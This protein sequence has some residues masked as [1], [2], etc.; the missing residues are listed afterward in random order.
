MA[1]FSCPKCGSSRSVLYRKSPTM[2]GLYCND[3]GAWVKWVGKNELMRCKNA[4]IPF[5]SEPPAKKAIASQSMGFGVDAG[6]MGFTQVQSQPMMQETGLQS[7]SPVT[8]V[9][10]VPEQVVPQSV[11]QPVQQVAQTVVQ[12]ML[13]QAGKMS[14]KFCNGLDSVVLPQFTGFDAGV[15]VFLMGDVL[16]IT[17]KETKAVCGMVRLRRCPMCGGVL[18]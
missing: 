1:I 2:V 14:C 17:N 8:S 18:G 11:Q 7:V 13:S 12:P 10:F 16:T 15:D 6:S 9:G 4:G 5:V 3:C